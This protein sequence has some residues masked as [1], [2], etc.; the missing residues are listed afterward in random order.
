LQIPIYDWEEPKTSRGKIQMRTGEI[1]NVGL[2]VGGGAAAGYLDGA[3]ADKQIAGQGLGTVLAIGGIAL[4]ITGIGGKY[5]GYALK[6]GTGAA[7]FEVGK[8]VLKKTAG[9]ATAGVRGV[10]GIAGVRGVAGLPA[11]RRPLTPDEWQAMTENLRA[12]QRAA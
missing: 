9:G 11:A 2:Q 5:G 3:M 7:A 10:R 1:F 8:L 4:G 12:A 6:L